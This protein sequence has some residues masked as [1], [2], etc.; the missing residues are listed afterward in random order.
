MKAAD[1]NKIR[2]FLGSLVKKLESRSV[3]A[4]IS[5]GLPRELHFELT[6]KCDSDCKMC[7]LKYLR[8][9]QTADD[10][11][12]SDIKKMVED[13]IFLKHIKLAV[14]SG[15]EPWLNKEFIDILIYL[16]GIY[17]DSHLLMLS[18]MN[19]KDVLV[20]NLSRIKDSIGLDGMSL[21][22]SL[23][24]LNH[25]HDNIR[26]VPG[27]FDALIASA[28]SVK[29]QFPGFFFSFNFTL[30][31]DNAGSL[32]DVFKWSRDTGYAV[33]FQS[34][35]QKKET[36]SM[37]FTEK[38]LK[39]AD[40]QINAVIEHLWSEKRLSGFGP[41]MLF[42]DPELMFLLMNFHYMYEYMREPSRFFQYCPCGRE[43]AMID[44]SGNIYLCPVNKHMLCGNIRKEDFDTIWESTICAQVR[45]SLGERKCHCWLSCTN[46]RQL[47]AA[48]FPHKEE[49][50]D[51]FL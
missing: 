18:N 33:S 10:I 3:P 2:I 26:G 36:D 45:S 50:A 17:P 38:H 48:Y 23:D 4:D 5:R 24:G 30:V 47:A 21:G 29:E 7:N 42:D 20:N 44:P 12:L 8:K 46:S 25:V 9:K 15:G 51:S 49:I 39:T 35:V 14:L 41:Q 34:A 16:R 19:N 1:I 22:S 37:V 6:Y 11:G 13:S 28:K 43:F 27:A 31:P 32:Y 40:E